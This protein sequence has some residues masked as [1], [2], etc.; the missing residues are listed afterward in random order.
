MLA[1][2]MSALVLSAS[3][4]PE[5]AG[6]MHQYASVALSPDGR[7]IAS[8]ETV[9]EPYATTEQHGA[10]VIRTSEGSIV[11]RLDVCPTCKYSDLIWAGD[12]RRLAFVASADGVATLYGATRRS[13]VAPADPQHP[14]VAYRIAQV[15]GLLAAPRWSPQ[16]NTVAVL[17]TVG[18][19]KETGATQAGV[20]EVGEVGG[21]DDSNRIAVTDCCRRGA[22][23][24]FTGRNLRLRIRLD[25]RRARIRGHRRAGKWG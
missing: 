25:S 6:V 15:K 2:V 10:V 3:A 23:V 16:G 13:P 22:E 14:Y 17:A 8:V 5:A 19:H 9:R 7:R 1:V 12:G 20:R 4:E 24:C 18:A 21:S 11:G